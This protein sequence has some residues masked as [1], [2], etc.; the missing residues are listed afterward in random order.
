[1]DYNY[2]AI[3]IQ[4]YLNQSDP[5]YLGEA[6]LQKLLSTFSCHPNPDVEYFLLHN[7][8]QFAKKVNRL[9][10]WYSI[11]SPHLL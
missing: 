11:R 2:Q 10:T 5:A 6:G 8:I 4:S 1:M 7:A 9:L 3:N